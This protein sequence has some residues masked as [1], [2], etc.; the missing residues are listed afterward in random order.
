[1]RKN[2]GAKFAALRK[3]S[4]AQLVHSFP[5]DF[6]KNG[7]NP[8]EHEQ[9]EF[10]VCEYLFPGHIKL[11]DDNKLSILLAAV[12]YLLYRTNYNADNQRV[13]MIGIMDEDLRA[14]ILFITG[15]ST[16]DGIIEELQNALSESVSLENNG[17]PAPGLIIDMRGRAYTNES[18][19][20]CG[21]SGA[22]MVMNVQGIDRSTPLQIRITFNCKV[23][24]KSSVERFI[25]YYFRI[26]EAAANS[27]KRG[28]KNRLPLYQDLVNDD[29]KKRLLD[30]FNSTGR[31]YPAD[32][33]IWGLF[34]SQA[35]RWPNRT[36]LVYE[37][38]ILSYRELK[39]RAIAAANY[40]VQV[41]HLN[42]QEP[43]GVLMEKSPNVIIGILGIFRAGG[44]FVPLDP[45]LP[46]SRIKM[47][48]DDTAIGVVL[49]Q[50]RCLTLIN[51]LLW[52][53][54]RFHSYLCMDSWNAYEEE[55]TQ[56]NHYM[57]HDFWVHI[58]ETSVDDITGG[59][60][61]SSYTGLPFSRKEIDECSQNVLSK[62]EPLLHDNMRILEIGVASGITMF[63]LAPRVKLYY[64]TDMS[65]VIIQKNM[66]RLETESTGN[67]KLK[68]LAA[69]DIASV[70]EKDFDLV[71]I[72]SV[73]Q[74]FHGYNYLRRI[75]KLAAS[76][77]KD[78]GWFFLG[79]IMDADLKQTLAKDLKSFKLNAE[80][81]GEETPVK[82]DISSELFLSRSFWL[83]WQHDTPW[84]KDVEFSLKIHTVE[85]ELTRYRYDVLVKIDKNTQN[86]NLHKNG[87]SNSSSRKSK[88][89]DDLRALQPLREPSTGVLSRRVKPDGAAYIIYT[90]G[91]TGRPKGV[92]IPHRGIASLT[93]V[94]QQQLNV[95][96]DDRV[97]QFAALSFDASIWDIFLALTSGAA[98]CMKTNSSA[99]E[100]EAFVRFL[101]RQ[102]VTAVTLPPSFLK[103][104]EPYSLD[105]LRLLITAGS[106]AGRHIVE[107]WR[108]RVQYVNAYGP[109]ESTICTTLW[110]APQDNTHLDVIPIG[111][112][113]NNLNVH[114]LD[115]YLNLQFPCIPGELCIS[116][117]PLAR[118]YLNR[119]ELTAERFIHRTLLKPGTGKSQH[120]VNKA[121]DSLLLYRTGDL[122]RWLESGTIEFLGRIDF[123]VK[124]RGFRIE[125]G[126]VENSI[127]QFHDIRES[128]V[129][130]HE[131][132]AGETYLCAYIVSRTG[133]VIDIGE[134]R[135]FLN[136]ELPHYMV[137]SFIMQLDKMPL[138]S[139]GKV[140][141]KKLPD[142]RLNTRNSNFTPPGT[143]MEK[144][145]ISIWSNVLKLDPAVIS[146]DD[147]FFQL[148]GHSLKAALMV[149]EIRKVFNVKVP[150]GTIFDVPTAKALSAYIDGAVKAVY[151]RIPPVEA[152][153]YYPQSSAQKRLFILHRMDKESTGYNAQVMEIRYGLPDKEKMEWAFTQL[154]R[155]HESLRTSF[156]MI[157]GEA[158]QQV[159]DK[160]DF[161]I[162]CY[163]S[164]EGRTGL[165]DRRSPVRKMR[166][167][168]NLQ[169]QMHTTHSTPHLENEIHAQLRKID[170]PVYEIVR[171]FVRPFDLGCAPLLRVG[172]ITI[173]K[174]RYVLMVDM[175]HI[176]SDG[177]SIGIFLRD[178]RALM[179]GEQLPPLTIQYKD[180][181]MW[182]ASE[183]GNNHIQEQQEFWLNQ[184]TG[185]LPV[186]R[187]PE[188]HIEPASR[189]ETN[190]LYF[191]LDQQTS[192]KLTALSRSQGATMFMVF[193]A[194]FNVL[195]AKLSGQQ[196][197]VVGTVSAGRGHADLKQIVGVFVNTLALRNFPILDKRF[198]EFLQDVKERSLSAFENQ[199][200]AFEDLVAKT[201]SRREAGRHPLFD[202]A[203]VH[204]NQADRGGDLQEVMVPGK[205]KPYR[206]E[207]NKSKF[208][209][210][211]MS[212]D[213]PKGFR[214]SLEF[215]RNRFSKETAE[216]Y[217]GYFKI[218]LETVA[219]TPAVRLADIGLLPDEERWLL[220]REFN[221]TGVEYPSHKTIHGLFE[222]QTQKAPDH[223]AVVGP[224]TAPVTADD[225]LTPEF[226]SRK[227][228][229]GV[230]VTYAEL[231]ERA[232][233]LAYRLRQMGVVPGQIVPLAVNR[234]M[235][236]IVGIFGILKAGA[237]YLPIDPSYPGERI[238]YI[239]SDSQSSVL[240]TPAILQDEES[241]DLNVM[242]VESQ[243]PSAALSAPG[244]QLAYVIYTSGTTGWPKGVL[245]EHSSAVNTLVCRKAIY[246]LDDKI[247]A[248]QLFSYAFDGFV[249]SFFSPVISGGRIVLACNEDLKDILRLKEMIVKQCVTHFI[250]VPAL[251]G[252]IIE[253][254]SR[255]E[256]AGLKIVTLAGDK[257]QSALLETTRA[258]NPD[259]EI[260][261]EYGVTEASVMSTIYRHQQKDRVIKIG[262]PVWNTKIFII[263]KWNNLQPLGVP[264]ELIIGGSG[265]ARGYLNRPELT[266]QRFITCQ[267]QFHDV[268]ESP[269]GK[270]VLSAALPPSA[271]QNTNDTHTPI[272]RDYGCRAVN[273][274]QTKCVQYHTG[275]M[276]RWLSDGTLEFLGRIDHQ[277]KVKGYRI[278]VGEIENQILEHKGVKEVV[279]MAR[280]DRNNM[281]Y[282]CAYYVS[283]AGENS[284]SQPELW[285][286]VA[287]F[288][289]YDELLYYAMTN[290]E[291][292]NSSYKV[293]FH[294]MLKNKVVV[295]IG[296]GQDAILSRF[297]VEAGAARVYAI[298]MLDE[299]FK[300]ARQTIESL[301]LTDK[302]K[303][304]YGDA[305]KVSLPEKA[306]V[307]ISEIV[308]SIGGS[309]GA[310]VILN[311]ARRFLKED[312]RMIPARSLTKIAAVTLPENVRKN[313]GFAPVAARYTEKVFRSF[314]YSFDL[315]LCIRNFPSTHVISESG[316]FEDLDFSGLVP[317][318]DS[319]T[320]SIRINHNG[321]MDGFLLWLT[322]E[323]IQGEIIDTLEHEYCWLPVYVP[324]FYPGVEVTTGDRIEAIC[325]RTL[326]ENGIN[327]DFVLHGTLERS[328]APDLPFHYELPHFVRKYRENPFYKRLFRGNQSNQ[329]VSSIGPDADDLR[330]FIS[331][332]LP[333][334]MLPSY[335]IQLDRMPLTA[336]GKIDRSAFIDPKNTESSEGQNY[337]P[338]QTEYQSLMVDIWQQVLC[339]DR[340]GIDDDFFVLGGDS[341][342][343]LQVVARL[344]KNGLK[345]DANRLF[346]YKTIKAVT[347]F[348]RT[349]D[350]D[351]Q[352]MKT[353]Y[354]GPVEGEV[355]LTP[356]QLW[357]Y[358]H[359][360]QTGKSFA[361]SAVIYRETGF[362]DTSVRKVFTHLISHHD[363]LRMIFTKKN[364]TVKQLNR[365]MQGELFHMEIIP[366]NET[367]KAGK[368]NIKQLNL[369]IDREIWRV[370]RTLDWREEPLIK[371]VLFKG[372]RGDYLGIIIHHLVI[373]GVS[374]RIL[375][376]DFDTAYHQVS[377][378]KGIVLPEKTTSF[379]QW[380]GKLREY[381]HS[382]LILRHLEY[383]RNIDNE[384]CRPLPTDRPLGDRKRVFGDY[385]N[386]TVDLNQAQTLAL[387]TH[388]NSAYNTAVNDLL[389]TALA[390]AAGTW[391][392]CASLAIHMEGHGREPVVKDIDISRTVGW[393]TSQ[394]PVILDTRA[395][396]DTGRIIKITK[397]TLR[398]IP[399]K[400]IDYG[401]LKYLTQ[402]KKKK[403]SILDLK[404]DISFNY[405]G[406]FHS[407]SKTLFIQD[408]DPEFENH[409]KLNIEGITLNDR[410]SFTFYYNRCEYDPGSINQLIALFRSALDDIILHC[411]SRT[412]SELTP[413]D[414][415]Y[416]G[417]SLE[418]LEN[419]KAKAV[420]KGRG[421][422]AIYPL[423]PMQR[424]MFH[425]S[426]E[427][428][429]AYFT[430]NLMTIPAW[431][432]HELLEKSFSLLMAQYEPMRTRFV[433]GCNELK[434][435]VQVI[436]EHRQEE[437][438]IPVEDISDRSQDEQNHYLDSQLAGERSDG[439]DLTRCQPQRFRRFKT[440]GSNDILMWNLHHII[441]DGWC[442]G[443]LL[444]KLISVYNMLDLGR[445]PKL[446]ASPSHRDF[447]SWQREQDTGKALNYW[448]SLLNGY[449]SDAV[450][451]TLGRS[452][453]YRNSE[454]NYRL[455]EHYFKLDIERSAALR[456]LA[457]RSRVTLNTVYQTL[458]ATLLKKH[459]GKRDVVFGS[460]V[461]GRSADF[462][463]IEEIV[464][465]M[466][467]VL[468]VRVQVFRQKSFAHILQS[469]QRQS[470]KSRSYEGLPLELEE[471]LQYSGLNPGVLDTLF[472]FENYPN[473]ALNNST[474]SME[475]TVENQHPLSLSLIKNS[476]QFHFDFVVYIVPGSITSIRFSYNALV[477]H[478]EQVRTFASDFQ[479]LTR[480]VSAGEEIQYSR[481]NISQVMNGVT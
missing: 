414:L 296:T 74:C 3:L 380:S 45:A 406:E 122:A 344:H 20:L 197:I 355:E 402:P 460:L 349:I 303:L 128:A 250:S 464:G 404:P 225:E 172:L 14:A 237:A 120:A 49:T 436:L 259:L 169:N 322:L 35:E 384:K 294:Q 239:L 338:P 139:S 226:R 445:T 298:E 215:D 302:I 339:L 253:A 148:G 473:A 435:P 395:I 285:P 437:S 151:F 278:E 194:A 80:A 29:E 245:V 446:P 93:T 458:W 270:E 156:D 434:E 133:R 444:S 224:D 321:R 234:S 260:A 331:R 279:V 182:A 76:L 449:S 420:G 50:K 481:G 191:E 27:G 200:Y 264:G 2:Y 24:R 162:E 185:D 261:H 243:A 329:A 161:K 251:Y 67:I 247:I 336:N 275:D 51:R 421:I 257:T 391:T 378:R 101:N 92:I 447:V 281:K 77:L 422:S 390:I 57:N 149:S 59:G 164:S 157:D 90:S 230:F 455:A 207:L 410:M 134:L 286:S 75:L 147:D 267:F 283:Q 186:L 150:V 324:V 56:H 478:P 152:R 26:L 398:R 337:T 430:G 252:A 411:Q 221:K 159:H 43:V 19:Q 255:E 353:V 85:N 108:S 60:W 97:L 385:R 195:L 419:V 242:R 394:F 332:R 470:I 316:V 463:A 198:S 13:I 442:L 333:P 84:V 348:I 288:F 192:F 358:Q 70:D 5:F 189:A 160:V 138:T 213:T 244:S 94:F 173:R 372:R 326:C 363:A 40:L 166:D 356:I 145:L 238:H 425:H 469:V 204:Q 367:K 171:L 38:E 334:Y 11:P 392:R 386:I 227:G 116:G 170:V 119:P 177:M 429:E 42:S 143:D 290:D 323:T 360:A 269:Q 91:S 379:K 30:D 320:I 176:I 476:E 211:L 125:P 291:R 345:L 33:N 12:V 54:S 453:E 388:A 15:E 123:Q 78:T 137:P 368:T 417:I 196:D 68:T 432:R 4:K 318:E 361:Q 373:D 359:H 36:A 311:K 479:L 313:P 443:I 236:M 375:L 383:W 52:S 62:L 8:N 89:Q 241:N 109:T 369:F 456:K 480:Q 284:T 433:Y 273:T 63:N 10:E 231:D 248:L 209:F 190:T 153:D 466:I 347:P 314:G 132:Q 381:A 232:G 457:G 397:E 205:S 423:T 222:E 475:N 18:E 465:L 319:H 193:L 471:I 112:P 61:I 210:T 405:L 376:E 32:K 309:E 107:T 366:L 448:K 115:S 121:G 341:I 69:H 301:G 199:D 295:E 233:K 306:D 440:G 53:C 451:S 178:F 98:L 72:N 468:P 167:R 83:D 472:I 254:M 424:T 265:I 396:T 73:I 188:D 271:K 202:T 165:Q 71:I 144:K 142:P 180:F 44:V 365:G 418:C 292:R 426:R 95:S 175:H 266:A 16:F 7:I 34:D 216:R 28:H 431:T 86:R 346:H 438:K 305:N 412:V 450:L 413:S 297:A 126:E 124:V 17:L 203:F 462:Q 229:Q 474:E 317:E 454:D 21:T 258:K 272:E 168:H 184:F 48:I 263:D 88:W 249:T 416:A 47:M 352:S 87:K 155:R 129:I 403:N 141:R 206:F 240:I 31:D 282:L 325:E 114:I 399:N 274:E 46:E 55:E 312:G 409:Y 370:R 6:I 467:E 262:R 99:V 389:V 79:D 106:E 66:Q 304:I 387:R 330:E 183:A 428:K 235:E 377:R 218:I 408:I 308:G 300:K 82:T 343:S 102:S 174:S 22:P 459:T 100:P 441:L 354:R 214:F 140:D 181:T 335:F 293:A 351:R 287:E 382:Y 220:V 401:I 362:N 64:G 427:N 117:F 315:R 357:F 113:I 58:G 477:Y 310:A 276:A 23:Y 118:G 364:R 307:L 9:K 219:G 256:A 131:D 105:S 289:I 452:V 439:F 461:S 146:M 158:V 342:K 415:G 179:D 280:E 340:V 217:S 400:G 1:M 103:L 110:M 187:V 135:T 407:S 96:E 374:W 208:M 371:L 41:K 130:A 25:S 350:N 223:I 228:E 277:V 136:Q 111:P 299:S 127:L 328:S 163:E 268:N 104:L 81:R 201:V 327:P 154:I 393:F 39:A 212:V 246:Q 65:P 37:E